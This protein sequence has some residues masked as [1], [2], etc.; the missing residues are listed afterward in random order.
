MM[1]GIR[2]NYRFFGTIAVLGFLASLVVHGMTFA[3]VDVM[4]GFPFAWLLHL[5]IFAV[6]VP[7]F[8]SARAKYGSSADPKLCFSESPPWAK[9]L[10]LAVGAYAFVNFALFMH[11]NEGGVP[12]I[13]NGKFVLKNHGAVIR[14]LTESEYRLQNAYVARGFSGHWLVFYLVPALYFLTQ[15]PARR[16]PSGSSGNV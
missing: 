15:T 14:P 6:F 12:E 10:A 4:D 9:W 8:L 13:E 16:E 2:W 11:F 3:G 5:G 7:F 1:D